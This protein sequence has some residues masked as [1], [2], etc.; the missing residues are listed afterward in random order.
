MEGYDGKNIILAIAKPGRL[1]SGPGT[2]VDNR[3]HYSL[4]SLVETT[5][6]FVDTSVIKKL[7][8]ENNL[9]FYYLIQPNNIKKSDGFVALVFFYNS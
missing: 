9:F 5:A 1:I 3:H 8:M 2:Y 7:V 4:A 6:C